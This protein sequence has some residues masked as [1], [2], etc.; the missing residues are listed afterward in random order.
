M[1]YDDK[2]WA[3]ICLY[4]PAF[5]DWEARWT[6]ARASKGKKSREERERLEFE[7]LRG[8]LGNCNQDDF[9]GYWYSFCK[10][11]WVLSDEVEHCQ[12]CRQCKPSIEWHCE[13]HD[14]C[15][16]NHICPGC[17]GNM[18]YPDMMAYTESGS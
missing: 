6:R 3:N 13:K 17:H 16:E 8:G 14:Q 10:S 12:E 4:T 7:L 1:L 5:A 2:S 11:A 18:Q 9:N 15:T